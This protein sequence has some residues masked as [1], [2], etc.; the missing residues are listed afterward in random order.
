[1]IVAGDMGGTHTRLA[2]VEKDDQQ[3]FRIR[4]QETFPSVRYQGLEYVVQEFL[5]KRNLAVS[6]A[7]V[8]VA[9]PV[10]SGRCA[11]MN[12][13]WVIEAQRVA[14]VANI[15]HVAVINDLE[16]SAYGIPC[17]GPEDLVTINPGAP[18]A[19]GN[20][21]VVS[22]GTGLGEAG[23]YWDGKQ[24]HPFATEG[25]H[26]D[27]APR[28]P[29]EFD[30]YQDLLKLYDHVSYERIVS[31]PGLVNIYRF[32][33]DTGRGEEPAWL[34]AEM[35]QR[36][37]AACISNAALAGRSPLC[38]QALDVFLEL[39]GAEA[40]NMALKVMA[41]GGVWLGGGIVVKVLERLQASGGFM[42]A[43][44]DKGRLRQ[45][46]QNIPVRVILN[47]ATALLGAARYAYD[48]AWPV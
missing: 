42:R 36:D 21:A 6:R 1:M 35:A 10:K 5:S 14:A 48:L 15:E 11:A 23:M 39:Y 4:E 3:R 19:I 40:G 7:C 46:M 27:F 20:G 33:R 24:F 34:T 30:L 16:A 12:L 37:A 13:P 47:D 25:G 22:A 28:N 9:G 32:L 38:E 26:T 8:G 18:E 45:L 2:L 31:G 41:R 43:F 44:T 17:L 29:L